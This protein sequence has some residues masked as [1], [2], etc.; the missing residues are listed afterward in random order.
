METDAKCVIL[1]VFKVPPRCT[2]ASSVPTHHAITKNV[3]FPCTG[4]S[5][6]SKSCMPQTNRT[7]FLAEHGEMSWI[8]SFCA[9]RNALKNGPKHRPMT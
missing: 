7:C 5:H 2:L 1:A 6:K 4:H 3:F 8:G 9:Q